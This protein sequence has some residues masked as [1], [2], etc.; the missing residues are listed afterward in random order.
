MALPQLAPATMA[1]VMVALA[2]A[3]TVVT[4]HAQRTRQWRADADSKFARTRHAIAAIPG[5]DH[6]Q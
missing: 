5:S 6:G 2:S 1:I 4:V 3:T